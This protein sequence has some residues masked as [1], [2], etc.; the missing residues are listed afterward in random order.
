MPRF[1]I[2][3][4]TDDHAAWGMRLY[5]DDQDI[6][7]GVGYVLFAYNGYSAKSSDP[8]VFHYTEESPVVGKQVE[9]HYW[10]KHAQRRSPEI[11]CPKC[12]RGR[13]HKEEAGPWTCDRCDYSAGDTA[14][15]M[16]LRKMDGEKLS[17]VWAQEIGDGSP[18]G[19]KVER[20]P[21]MTLS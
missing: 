21:T 17:E 7:R 20:S 11:D 10:G 12:E 9:R 13:M 19:E 8:P 2:E 5:R 3:F 4:D 1:R 16:E 15:G 6:S 14:L 18:E